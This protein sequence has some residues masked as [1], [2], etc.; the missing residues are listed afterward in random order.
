MAHHYRGS[1]TELVGV[2]RGDGTVK[3]AHNESDAEKVEGVRSHAQ[4]LTARSNA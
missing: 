1:V 4:V 2:Q 3:T